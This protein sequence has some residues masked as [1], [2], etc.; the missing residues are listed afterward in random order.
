MDIE[1]ESLLNASRSNKPHR[2]IISSSATSVNLI[3][4]PSQTIMDG[5]HSSLSYG[6][7][8]GVG[9]EKKNTFRITFTNI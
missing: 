7:I 6:S 4:E 2:G 9:A 5:G 8:N 1:T 3:E